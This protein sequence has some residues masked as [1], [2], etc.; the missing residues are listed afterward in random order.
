MQENKMQENRVQE[1][2]TNVMSLAL[3][4]LPSA[5]KSS[6][7]NAL[8]GKRIA[9]CGVMR[10]TINIHL[11]EGL[12]SDDGINYQIYDLPG[13]DDIEDKNNKFDNFTY[14]TIKK[15]DLVFW[16]SDISKPFG[17]N[18]EIKEFEKI[19]TYINKLRV[20]NNV[21][22]QLVILLSKVDSNVNSRPIKQNN[23][24]ET[25]NIDEI[26]E[27]ID[28]EDSSSWYVYQKIQEKFINYDVVCFN[29]F[30]RSL[31]NASSSE[32]LKSYVKNYNPSMNNIMFNIS[33]YYNA[34]E[35]LQN[36]T[37][38]I[39][40][41]HKK[42]KPFIDEL[43][44]S[45][46]SIFV[47]DNEVKNI[48]EKYKNLS[49]EIASFFHHLYDTNKIKILK[50]LLC[51]TKNNENDILPGFNFGASYNPAIW[52]YICYHIKNRLSH[53]SILNLTSYLNSPNS[54]FRIIMMSADLD[55]Y[56]KMYL[57]N[58]VEA[59]IYLPFKRSYRLGQGIYN[60]EYFTTEN[61]FNIE[62]N[63][64][65]LNKKYKTEIYRTSLLVEIKKY[66]VL[67][68]GKDESDIS[69]DMI[70]IAYHEHGLFWKP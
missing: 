64:T 20:E 8:A 61:I 12:Q 32:T 29:A 50:F 63:D 67:I 30:G 13:L 21:T 47:S 48:T 37:L 53:K 46:N 28:D 41:I 52:N 16:V 60:L 2:K 70:P 40:F 42:I 58:H 25:T 36:E 66:R 19:N 57:F 38:L 33:K 44:N 34:I 4:G 59:D 23:R 14:E 55:K 27:I 18:H 62:K 49:N 26:T 56:Q 22:I 35:T 1:N 7:I 11:Y 68:Y 15:C 65:T 43:N 69:I 39:V 51:D 24:S 45:S 3:I 54:I 9:K 17:T 5:G 10:T 31:H 6:I